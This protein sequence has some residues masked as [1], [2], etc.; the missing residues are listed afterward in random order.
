MKDMEETQICISYKVKEA[1]LKRLH[2][3]WFQLYDSL[4]K[5]K[6]YGDSKKITVSQWLGGREGWIGGAQIFRAVKPVCVMLSW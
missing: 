2:I 6:E 5:V 4:E 3:V 1:S